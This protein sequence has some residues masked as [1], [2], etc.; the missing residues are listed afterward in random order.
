MGLIPLSNHL[1]QWPVEVHS[2]CFPLEGKAFTCCNTLP[3]VP[4]NVV[5]MDA[6][7]NDLKRGLDNFM[8]SQWLV[9]AMM[10]ASLDF[11]I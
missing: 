7:C 8:G 6:S 9:L 11:H 5:V 4:G 3:Q 2:T 10:V 1:C